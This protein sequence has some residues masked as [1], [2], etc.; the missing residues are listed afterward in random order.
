MMNT[1]LRTWRVVFLAVGI[2]FI[3]LTTVAVSQGPPDLEGRSPVL[4]RKVE[5]RR[6]PTPQPVRSNLIHK[7]ADPQNGLLSNVTW[8]LLSDLAMKFLSGN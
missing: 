4:E 3:W 7:L 2:A 6:A 1:V 8:D 5:V